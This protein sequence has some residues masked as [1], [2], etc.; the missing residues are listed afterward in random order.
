MAEKE[1]HDGKKPPKAQNEK[2]N[3]HLQ[4]LC[5]EVRRRSSNSVESLCLRKED[6]IDAGGVVA[7]RNGTVGR[8]MLERTLLLTFHIFVQQRR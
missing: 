3:A 6:R 2:F 7:V 5:N 8:R 1:A 4:S